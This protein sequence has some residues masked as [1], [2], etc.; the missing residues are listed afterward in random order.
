MGVVNEVVEGDEVVNVGELYHVVD[1][2]GSAWI[3]VR[4]VAEVMLV[5]CGRT[6]LDV[7]DQREPVAECHWW[8]W[9]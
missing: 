3:W 8:L 1:G 6:C 5:R 9:T 7:V 4:I 2:N